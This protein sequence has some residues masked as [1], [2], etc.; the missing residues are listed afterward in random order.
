MP[1]L[2][3]SA[4]L[5][6]LCIRLSG[7]WSRAGMRYNNFIARRSVFDLAESRFGRCFPLAWLGM[8]MA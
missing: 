6:R 5:C 1:A 3:T 7:E 8:P 4:N 2:S